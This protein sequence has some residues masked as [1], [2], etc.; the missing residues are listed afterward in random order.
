MNLG[1][2]VFGF[3]CLIKQHISPSAAVVISASRVPVHIQ[4]WDGFIT[5]VAYYL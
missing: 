1:S 2:Q 4:T 5:Y 3:N